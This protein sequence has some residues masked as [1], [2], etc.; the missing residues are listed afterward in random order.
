MTKIEGIG[1]KVQ[2]LLVANGITTYVKLAKAKPQHLEQMLDKAGSDYQMMDPSTWPEQATMASH[3][4]WVQLRVWQDELHDGFGKPKVAVIETAKQELTKIEGI[5]PQV[6]RLLYDAGITTFEQ[7]AGTDRKTLEE[8]LARGGKRYRI[9]TPDTWADQAQLAATGKWPQLRAFQDQLDGQ[10]DR[11][12]DSDDLTIVDGIDP[13]IQKLLYA[14]SIS[15]YG[16]LAR[17]NVEALRVI[18][19]AAGPEF[20]EYD[21]ETWPRQATLA[22]RAQWTELKRFQDRLSGGRNRG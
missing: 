9:V 13:E 21:P 6:Q 17:A 7:L 4:Q 10:V 19:A 20:V 5:G 18:L 22:S 2:Q 11:P 16:D 1:S 8:I 15:S 12:K 3:G 14:S